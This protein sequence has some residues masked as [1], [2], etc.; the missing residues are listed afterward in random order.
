M[1][2]GYA[3]DAG[4]VVSAT[5]SDS[6]CVDRHHGAFLDLVEHHVDLSFANEP[7]IL[8]LYCTDDFEAALSAVR[9]HVPDVAPTRSTRARWW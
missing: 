4:R 1:A 7:E 6:F 3:H 8:A 5:L 9:E 2:A